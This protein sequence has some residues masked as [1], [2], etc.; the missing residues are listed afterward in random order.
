MQSCSSSSISEEG[1]GALGVAP[2]VSHEGEQRAALMENAKRHSHFYPGD[3]L[4]MK[5]KTRV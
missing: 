2:G 5:G 1:S 4:W 3:S